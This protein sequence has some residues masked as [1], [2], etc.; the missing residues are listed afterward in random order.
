MRK[1]L[2]AAA[3]MT[4]IVG[5]LVSGAP[6]A[7]A[8]T[9]ADKKLGCIKHTTWVKGNTRYVK[10]RNGCASTVKVNL[11]QTGPDSGYKKINVGRTRTWEGGQRAQALRSQD[12]LQGHALLQQAL[13]PEVGHLL[14]GRSA[15]CSGT[16]RRPL[17]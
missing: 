10:V 15:G 11:I 17:V 7:S 1:I 3:L 6:A 4:G 5:T 13:E 12:L 14:T 2:V 16:A 9:S 8:A